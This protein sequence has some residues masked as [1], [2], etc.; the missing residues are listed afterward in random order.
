LHQ[1]FPDSLNLVVVVK[2]H[3]PSGKPAQAVWFS[4]DLHRSAAPLADDSS[5]RFQIEFNFRHAQQVWG[6]EDFMNLSEQAV[7]PAANLAFLM[8]NRSALLL[9]PSRQ[10]DPDFSVLDLKTHCRA[11]RYLL[12]TL[13]SL[14]VPPDDDLFSRLWHRFI[15]LGGI[16]HRHPDQLAAYLATVLIPQMPLESR[17]IS[18]S[19]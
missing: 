17:Q 15:R 12:E 10:Q 18:V 2:T 8:V 16:R 9:L 7:T 14:P 4:T 5:L 11:R 6:L 3:Q 13:K 19:M 1:D